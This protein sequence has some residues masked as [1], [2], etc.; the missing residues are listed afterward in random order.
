LYDNCDVEALAEAAIARNRWE[1]VLAAA[2]LPIR[3][4]GL[5]LNPIATF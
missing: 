3:G 4:T 5:P 2:P 1:F